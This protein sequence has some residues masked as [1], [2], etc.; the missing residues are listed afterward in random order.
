[1]HVVEVL[2]LAAQRCHLY[3]AVEAHLVRQQGQQAVDDGEAPCPAQHVARLRPGQLVEV[4]HR[5]LKIEP[6]IDVVAEGQ[7]GG[8]GGNGPRIAG[9]VTRDLDVGE[10]ELVEIA[11]GLGTEDERAQLALGIALAI[12]ALRRR[13]LDVALGET[14]LVGSVEAVDLARIVGGLGLDA[15]EEGLALHIGRGVERKVDRLVLVERPGAQPPRTGDA[16]RGHVGIDVVERHRLAAAMVAIVHRAAGERDLVELDARE[17]VAVDE[18]G[19]G[20][21]H[22]VTLTRFQPLEVHLRILHVDALDVEAAL[23]QAL[24][25]HVDGDAAS[26]GEFLAV[27]ALGTGDLD[28]FDGEARPREEARRNGTLDDHLAARQLLAIGFEVGA[29]AVPVDDEGR[30]Q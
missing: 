14:V 6:G 30:G 1:M 4:E 19:R 3:A 21:E 10:V 5:G 20:R 16:G 2:A 17:D 26:R 8:A 28:V 24:Q 12:I 18:I 7:R 22:P 27:H 15:E 13:H 23:Q 25:R 9:I 29:V 11:L